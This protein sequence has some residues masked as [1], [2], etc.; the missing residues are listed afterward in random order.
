MKNRKTQIRWGLIFFLYFS[1]ITIPNA[2]AY[3]DPASGSF[4]F[5]VTIGA[6]LGAGL[7][8]K[9]FW[10]RITGFLTG[11]TRRE[12]A[13]AEAQAQG[14]SAARMPADARTEARADQEA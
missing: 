10:R 3:I 13:A 6:L 8:I 2:H 9:M 11:R 7:A 4:L 12:R 1:I 14:Q 5:Q